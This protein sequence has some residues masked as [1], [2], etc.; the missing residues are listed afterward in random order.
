MEFVDDFG[1]WLDEKGIESH[2]IWIENNRAMFLVPRVGVWEWTYHAVVVISGMVHDPWLSRA[3]PMGEYFANMFPDQ[4][5]H[6][7]HFTEVGSAIRQTEEIW[8]N[9]E[10][11]SGP[12]VINEETTTKEI[13]TI[14]G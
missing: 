7:D 14:A 1:R 5:L 8:L 6:V 13:S 11:L 3:M 12:V 10:L 4:T 2:H 9:N